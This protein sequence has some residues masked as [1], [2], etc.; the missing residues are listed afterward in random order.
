MILRMPEQLLE[1][2]DREQDG[3]VGIAARL[4]L[5]PRQPE[6]GIVLG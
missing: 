1:L 2:V 4:S 3:G 5:L 6:D